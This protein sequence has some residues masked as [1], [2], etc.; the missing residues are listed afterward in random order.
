MRKIFLHEETVAP[1]MVD[2]DRTTL[3]ESLPRATFIELGQL[4]AYRRS[5][6]SADVAK[7][8]ERYGS[9]RVSMLCSFAWMSSLGDNCFVLK[10]LRLSGRFYLQTK[11]SLLV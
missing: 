1:A 8:V 4:F 10:R 5:P 9:D 11:P 2:Y 7:V 6:E 3:V